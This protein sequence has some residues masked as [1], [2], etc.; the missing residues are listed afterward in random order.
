MTAIVDDQG[1]DVALREW[2]EHITNG[3]IT[4]VQRISGGAFRTSARID[5][6][7]ANGGTDSAFLKIDLGSAPRTPFDLR[8]EYHLLDRLDGRARAPRTIGWHEG[9]TAMAM[10][11]LPGDAVYA[12]I[13]DD[14][15]RR[16][17]ERSFADALVECHRVDIASLALD[18]LPPGLTIREAI[19]QE[20]DL[21]EGLLDAGVPDPDPLTLFAFRWL[22]ANL[23]A[24]D[25]PA[26][27]VQG[28][29]GAGNFLFDADGV[30]GLVDWEMTHLGHPLEDIACVL[31]RSLVQPMAS[32][33]RLME[34]YQAASGQHYAMRELLYAAV[35]V[36][37]RFSVPIALALESRHTGLDFGLTNG[38]FRLSQISLIQLVARAEG[39]T[40]DES[41][42]AAGQKPAVGFEFN[43]LRSVLGT[44]VRPAIDDPYVQ[45]R[46]D[47]AVGLVS[48]L[49]AAL[50]EEEKRQPVDAAALRDRYETQI[51]GGDITP[52][53]QDF[54]T[55]ALWR[56]HLM[57]DML[58]PLH[59]GRVLL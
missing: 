56:E 42:P 16:R 1:K 51:S 57:R 38:Y 33:E 50:A 47:G 52:M 22:R 53:L 34:I 28:D 23:P 21:W 8:R 45:Y 5:L 39:V 41:V 26:V 40:L 24:D 2:I 43:Y 35:L 55:D 11:C 20:L 15:H 30:T 18:H 9:A 46:L 6:T 7:A 3:R 31:A 44:I 36:M 25:R 48:Y 29:A 10:H 32:A 27:L 54:L 17:V 14:A 59:G 4:S 49:Q 13:T 37:T 12:R 19:R 58:G